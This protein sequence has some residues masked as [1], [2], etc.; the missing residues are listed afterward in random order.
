MTRRYV[1]GDKGARLRT[2]E[3]VALVAF[4]VW[5][6]LTLIAWQC[7]WKETFFSG[8]A[9]VWMLVLVSVGALAS[10]IAPI[11]GG[12]CLWT[13]NDNSDTKDKSPPRGRA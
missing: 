11:L 4:V 6:L 3:V 9:P 2:V 13:D 1:N 5:A 12:Y 8:D 10:L 7:G